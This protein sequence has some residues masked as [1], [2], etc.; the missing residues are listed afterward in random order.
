MNRPYPDGGKY[1]QNSRDIK[2]AAFMDLQSK[3][4]KEE[5]LSVRVLVSNPCI[6]S[7]LCNDLCPGK[8]RYYSPTGVVRMSDGP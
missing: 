3:L 4:C 8:S 1:A 7:M 5:Q 2:G 6:K